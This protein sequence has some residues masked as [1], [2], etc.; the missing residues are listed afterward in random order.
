MESTGKSIMQEIWSILLI[1]IFALCIRIFIFEPFY[2]PSGSMNNNL[3]F[4]D[5]P[6]STKYDYGYSRYSFLFSP[7]IFS[8]RIFAKQPKR[9]DIVIFRPPNNMSTRY[10]KRL[11][12]LPGDK[13]LLK[14]SVLY[15]NDQPVKREYVRKVKN[16]EGRTCDLYIETLPEGLRYNILLDFA[17][18]TKTAYGVD[19]D[20]MG[21]FYVPEGKFFFLGD[22]RHYSRD[23][24]FDLGYVPFENFIGKAK[25]LMF[26]A[27]E[28]LFLGLN[29]SFKDQQKQFYYWF[30]SFRYSRFF[31][32][33]NTVDDARAAK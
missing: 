29:A 27:E 8:G 24:R 22:N 19:S 32:N 5:Y 18:D 3:L 7:N 28:K 33:I 2:I 17:L 1:I 12:G 13:I 14:D 10:I 23:S 31:K 21:P 4:G 26:S 11:I 30:A 20:N 6:V 9:G 15:I 16:D 25:F